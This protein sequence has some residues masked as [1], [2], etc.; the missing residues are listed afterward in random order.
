M[1]LTEVPNVNSQT[2]I[3]IQVSKHI[4]N[5]YEQVLRPSRIQHLWQYFQEIIKLRLPCN[6]EH[7]FRW[8]I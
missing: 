4:N 1:N 2:K 5:H 3:H 6:L 8:K 7:I